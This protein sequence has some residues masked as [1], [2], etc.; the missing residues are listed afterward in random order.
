MM[1]LVLTARFDLGVAVATAYH[2]LVGPLNHVSFDPF[3]RRGRHVMSQRSQED[4]Q[5]RR[6]I[7]CHSLMK[8]SLLAAKCLWQILQDRLACGRIQ[9]LRIVLDCVFK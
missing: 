8:R 6:R 2:D 3:G 1:V 9:E 4:I 5:G 7:L